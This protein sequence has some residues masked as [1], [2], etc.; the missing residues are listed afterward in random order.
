MCVG[1]GDAAPA[2]GCEGGNRRCD[3]STAMSL[4]LVTLVTS[5]AENHDLA[6][7]LADVLAA[8]AEEAARELLGHS[9]E[10]PEERAI[11][12]NGKR[13]PLCTQA[14]HK[15]GAVRVDAVTA[16]TRDR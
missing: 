2:L 4:L 6:R 9:G 11:A 5:P 14:E 1:E 15:E 12:S 16:A 8:E 10:W 13:N 3:E 7:V